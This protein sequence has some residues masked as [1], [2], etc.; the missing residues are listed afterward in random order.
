MN[1]RTYVTSDLHL[2][3]QLVAK[4][5]GFDR[6]DDHDNTIIMNLRSIVKPQDILWILGDLVFSKSTKMHLLSELPGLVKVVLGNHDKFRPIDLPRNFNTVFG[7]AYGKHGILFTHIPV[8]E[9]QKD[10][11]TLNVHGHLHDKVIDD[12]WYFNVCLEQNNLKPFNM[13]DIYASIPSTSVVTIRGDVSHDRA[14][15]GKSGTP[16]RSSAAGTPTPVT[17]WAP[18]WDL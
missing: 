15:V 1:T 7:A 11:F 6:V 16:S 9:G 10:R 8:H 3:H 5:R 2:G 17:D 4:L 18:R 13:E 14:S 12:P